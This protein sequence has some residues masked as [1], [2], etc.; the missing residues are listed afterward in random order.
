[1]NKIVSTGITFIAASLVFLQPVSAN[2]L[3]NVEER[4]TRI[5]HAD[6]NLGTAAGIDTLNARVRRAAQRM[7]Q[8]FGPQT[9]GELVRGRQCSARAIQGAKA[10]V[11]EV[12][13]QVRTQRYAASVPLMR[14]ATK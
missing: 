7:C 2:P 12:V 1:M 3:T 13:D 5:L 8:R 4:S 6:L 14:A 11:T 10:Q 9:V